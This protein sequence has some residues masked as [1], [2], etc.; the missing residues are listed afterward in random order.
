MKILF[1]G[2]P[3]F[4]I[5]SLRELL[6]SGEEIV[7]VITQPDKPRGRGYELLPTPIKAFAL[8][9]GLDVY[10]PETLRG[11]EFEALLGKLSPE[12]IAV[13]AYG[14][15]LPENVINFPKYGCI[16]VHGSLLPEYRGAAPMQRAIIDGKSETGVTIMYM[17]KG[18]DTGDMLLVEKCNI[19]DSDNFEDI[20][21]R[22]SEIGAKALV[23]VVDSL[24]RGTAVRVPQDSS[25]ATYAAKIEKSDCAVDF[26]R[27]AREV[28]NLI[29]GLS[30][31]PL[32]FTRTPD[33]RLLKILETRIF[34][35]D[36]LLGKAGEVI[37]VGDDI[38]VACG[39]GA[40]SLLR[41]LPEGKGRMSAADFVR[42][43]KIKVGDI[44]TSTANTK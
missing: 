42:G 18:L 11:E 5:P 22:L 24:K 43:R 37:S 7:G 39:K 41:V 23:K 16:N 2:T 4:A 14:K 35:E 36:K 1:M 21:D 32:S 30:P 19:E 44:L 13:T 28:H 12:L 29:R 3:D 8:E 20:H 38:C 10:Q 25:R 27:S 15:I 33:G 6:L 9:H 26:S 17:E 31:I 34:D 40:V